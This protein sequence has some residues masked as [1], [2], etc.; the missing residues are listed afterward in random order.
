MNKVALK[1][2]KRL[3]SALW[4]HEKFGFRVIPVVPGEKRAATTWDDWLADLSAGK[5][6]QHWQKHPNHDVGAI[7][8]DNIIMFDADTPE[9]LSNLLAVEESFGV[10]P[11]LLIQTARGEHHYFKRRQGT[12]AASDGHDT[13]KHPGR[14]DI[15]T[16][17]SMVVLPPSTNKVVVVHEANDVS[18]LTEVCQLFIDAVYL[19]ND[20]EPPRP[21]EDSQ[22]AYVR[23]GEEHSI[24]KLRALLNHLDPDCGYQDWLNVLMAVHTE[25][26][27]SDEGLALVDEWS[28]KG[29][30]YT[31]GQEISR[32]WRSFRNSMGRL[33]TIG[34][35]NKMVEAAGVKWQDIVEPFEVEGFKV[36]PPEEP[37][38]PSSEN[39][40]ILDRFSLNGRSEELRKAAVEQVSILGELALQGQATVWY[41]E[42]NSGKTLLALKLLIDGIESRKINPEKIYYLNL[43]DTG[44]GL[45]E[46]VEIAEDYGF[47]ML[48]EGYQGFSAKNFIAIV[49]ELILENQANGIIVIADTIKKLVDMM[50]KDKCSDFSV[51]IRKFVLNGGTFIALAHTNKNKRDGK[52]VPCGT[53]D[54]RDDFDC[55][56]TIDT[57]TRN[58]ASGEK[59]VEFENIKRR[60]NVADQVAYGYSTRRDIGYAALLH[61]VRPVDLKQIEP[62]RQAEQLRSDG[63]LITLATACITEGIAS[64]MLLAKAISERSGVSRS[65]ALSIVERYTGNDPTRHRWQAKRGAHG[66]LAYELLETALAWPPVTP[67]D[68]DDPSPL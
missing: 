43:D 17:R 46:K 33:I 55:A 54:I 9:A 12:Y 49:R 42:P 56:Y 15:R 53:S 3:E 57:V 25:T 37:C 32:K 62:I 2:G 64:K 18:E 50:K 52:P 66:K 13:E 63:E 11:K 20:R 68:N 39:G 47:H 16:G 65:T 5:I 59:V 31:G 34:T 44:M 61:S 35:I 7:I 24:P 14:I 26:D 67:A 29:S 58:T 36:V 23:D 38:E 6:T 1:L 41:A 30:K 48:A 45:C 40:T 10:K 27:G 22:P 60:G 4:W 8:D 19:M 28:S 51:D 21:K